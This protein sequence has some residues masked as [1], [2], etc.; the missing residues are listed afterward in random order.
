MWSLGEIFFLLNH[1]GLR[2]E[3]TSENIDTF[4]A[5]VNDELQLA[6][7]ESEEKK[8]LKKVKEALEH[9]LKFDPKQ[10]WSAEQTMLFLKT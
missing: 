5:N 2:L 10:R 7:E 3:S 6:C 9:L 4:L 1:R 8:D